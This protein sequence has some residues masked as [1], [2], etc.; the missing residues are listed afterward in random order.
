MPSRTSL[1]FD[2]EED[3]VSSSSPITLGALRLVVSLGWVS[4]VASFQL[5]SL[6]LL[7]SCREASDFRLRVAR[8]TPRRVWHA[9]LG[10]GGP[11]GVATWS[12][13][14]PPKRSERLALP[15][16][17]RMLYDRPAF[18]LDEGWALPQELVGLVLGT[19]FG[20]E[21]DRMVWPSALESVVF[22]RRYLRVCVGL[23]LGPLIRTYCTCK[24]LVL[25]L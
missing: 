5:T 17:T 3:I 19:E 9:K 23:Y 6:E 15:R 4:R 21:M 18:D 14:A 10:G 25:R 12:G 13:K 24:E 20:G 7:V 8:K 1:P 16:V 11:G 22:W 2:G